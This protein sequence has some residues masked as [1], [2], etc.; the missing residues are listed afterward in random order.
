MT[1]VTIQDPVFIFLTSEQTEGGNSNTK[2]HLFETLMAIVMHSLGYDQPTT[3]HL[4]V[5][6]D[7]VE[8]DIAMRH[9]MNQS[10]AIAECKAYSTNIP[11]SMVSGFYGKLAVQRF[12]DPNVDGFFF[13]LPRLT[14]DADTFVS[15]VKSKDSRFQV[16]TA[17]TIF[18]LLESRGLITP[19]SGFE[20]SDPAVIIHKSGIYAAAIQLDDTRSAARIRVST[21]TGSVPQDVLELLAANA[22]ARGL[23][24]ARLDEYNPTSGTS[25]PDHPLILEVK[26]SSS[27]FEYQL[28]ASPKYFVGRSAAVKQVA[29]HITTHGGPFVL[30]AQSGWGKSSMALKIASQIDG[31]GIVLD[32]RTASS[33]AYVPAAMR[34]AAEKAVAKGYLTLAADASWATVQ[35]ALTS[36]AQSQWADGK[37]L[38]VI[39]DQFENVF[40][41]VELTGAFRDLALLASEHQSHV[42]VG[43]S[44]KTDYVDWTENHPF[45][46]RDQIR[47]VSQ[48][49]N[50]GPL[51][52]NEVDTILKRLDASA[53]AKLTA[54]L[55][56][57]LREYSQGLPWL[58]K[59]LSGHILRE[60]ENKK[61]QEQL[62]GEAL[63]VQELFDFDL[64]G[65]SAP[66]REAID[67]VAGFAPVRAVEAIDRFGA[68]QIQSLLNQRLVIQVGD[69]LDT[70][71]DTFRDYL[72]TGRVPIEDSYI[73]R[74]TPNS[75]AR[76]VSELLAQGG[77][78][79]TTSIA[80][81][82][83]TSDKV[84][85]NSV[86]ELRQLGLASYAA[87]QV[88]LI[89]EVADADDPE[90]ELRDHVSGALRRHRAWTEFSSLAE[91][92]SGSV[93][94]PLF[95]DQLSRTFTAVDGTAKTWT[96]YARNF[97]AWFT[98]AG[99]STPSGNDHRV[100]SDGVDGRGSLTTRATR[101]A[102]KG[103]FPTLAAG[104][105]LQLLQSWS[106]GLEVAAN[107]RKYVSQL[108][109]LGALIKDP[110]SDSYVV[111]DGLL[112]DGNLVEEKLLQL[113]LT[114]QG[115]EIAV[116][117]L[118][119]DRSLAGSA[120]GEIFEEAH[121]AKW[122]QS[123]KDLVG[124]S[125]LSWA[126]AAGLD[127]KRKSRK[128]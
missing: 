73:L 117:R 14:S 34:H 4:N 119:E 126:R 43:F 121:G 40:T 22:Y 99:L 92:G 26:G 47:E 71:W 23:E 96:T 63:N 16:F 17:T 124:R 30:N 66:E 91:R 88:K 39:F 110:D 122:T 42:T 59:K 72:N 45:K 46:L 28:P 75:V 105:A 36:L 12:S 69:K 97:L 2:G 112:V 67:F 13:A 7:G 127:T 33:T 62:I 76:L 20:F 64:A 49:V 98:Y 86:K 90:A 83:G 101:A 51:S 108:I 1:A 109:T 6:S 123:T 3:Q 24:V 54:E 89:S 8:L 44:W 70:Y 27:D 31:T 18:D 53:G 115:G 55:K 104:P 87:G 65:L 80:D 82:W 10:H 15:Q 118:R 106:E 103:V 48:V 77:T 128:R 85:G 57:R 35:G 120:I 9:E 95:A 19:V 111:T 79:S 84:V 61:T 116:K 100:A 74:Q 25:V 58:L 93:S 37:R 94:T 68:P 11:A 107:R 32:T 52:R 102:T 113:L 5:K 50:L 41:N 81:M 60:M 38:T 125:F 56:Q 29:E 78:G 21:S 114:V